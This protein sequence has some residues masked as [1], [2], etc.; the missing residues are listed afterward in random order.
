VHGLLLSD[1]DVQQTVTVFSSIFV[2]SRLLLMHY[3]QITE[4][5]C[6]EM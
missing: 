5:F 6:D 2:K 1:P 3:V 4:H